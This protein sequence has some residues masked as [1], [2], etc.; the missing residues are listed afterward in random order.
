MRAL[1][2]EFGWGNIPPEV[3]RLHQRF[4]I[5]HGLAVASMIGV[6]RKLEVDHPGLLTV[7]LSPKDLRDSPIRLV[8]YDHTEDDHLAIPH[9]D[10]DSL[11]QQLGESHLGLEVTDPVT[12]KM[13][14]V[15][16]TS[17]QGVVFAR[18]SWTLAFPDSAINPAWHQVV[19]LRELNQ[20]RSERG[21]SEYARWALIF[22]ANDLTNPNAPP[23]E[24]MHTYTK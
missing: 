2:E 1:H 6:L 17:G 5:V 15:I 22:F 14:P 20:G 19:N 8:L 3:E 7:S 13:K 4:E 9:F 11:T 16:R 24:A 18:H 10:K 12:G 23:R 21:L